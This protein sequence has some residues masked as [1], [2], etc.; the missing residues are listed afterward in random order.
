MVRARRKIRDARIP[1]AVPDAGD[2]P[3]RLAL[4]LQVVYLVFNEG[5]GAA[6]GARLV[7][8]DLGDE[9]IRLGR[10]LVELMPAQ[11]DVAGLLALMLIQHARRD[12][13]V[14]GEGKLLTLEHQD[15]SRW[16]AM[17]IAGGQ[18]ILE[19]ALTLRA[20][21]PYQVQA[22]IA[23][24]HAQA[25][26]TD[27]KQIA[28][29]YGRLRQFWPTAVVELNAAVAVGMADGYVHG[30]DLIDALAARGELATSHYLPAAR[31]D[32]LR[33][34]GRT[35]KAVAAFNQALALVSNQVERDYLL[36]QR[37][38]L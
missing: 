5:Y 12:A 38:A 23:S 15:R 8:A 1:Y 14:S 16:H 36:Q 33:R 7:R 20:A 6:S 24:L 3:E 27:W 30:L 28:L 2:L 10:L 9:A 21:G 26:S 22:A 32:L 18:A 34:L 4:V 25:G 19:H 17:E 11:A 13:R 37:N 29:L 35:E 31:A